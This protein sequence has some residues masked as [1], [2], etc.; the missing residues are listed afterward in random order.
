M[1]IGDRATQEHNHRHLL[2]I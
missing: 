1:D 2:W